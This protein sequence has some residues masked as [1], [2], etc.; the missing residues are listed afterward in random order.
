M[1]RWRATVL[2][3]LLS[4]LAMATLAA[5]ANDADFIFDD[6][7]DG[8]D[9]DLPAV[10]C[11]V[12]E[13]AGVCLIPSVHTRGLVT[14]TPS[15]A[16]ILTHAQA[17]AGDVDTKRFAGE[18]LGYVTPWNNH[19]YDMAKT[20]RRKFTYIA[21]VWYQIRHD[22]ARTPVLTG[23]HDADAN[24]IDAVRGHDGLGP[25]IVPRFMF[26]MPSLSAAEASQVLSLLLREVETH[27]FDGLT[28]EVPIV[29]VTVPFIKA[30]GKAL[31]KA[32]RLLLLVLP[33]S[34]RN[35]Q[36]SVD[37]RH[38]QAVLPYVHRISV[39]AYDYSSMGPNAPLPWL[40]ATLQQLTPPHKLL[41]GLA[42]YGYDTN[43]AVIASTY[44][45]LLQTH[46]PDVQWDAVA[47]EC[48]FI[49]AAGRRHVYYPCLQ[50]IDDRL[51]LY[52]KAHVGAAI[53]EIGQGLD[54]FYDLL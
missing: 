41:M 18:T 48:K 36:L 16:S 52:A 22:A 47:H 45:T 25:Q 44:L 38:L 7:D 13:A 2:A 14:T 10:A 31:A 11:V 53:W 49:Y 54:Y 12:D 17:Y 34:Q 42:F 9:D 30:L 40:Q 20:F 33:T 28:L 43:E 5:A 27:H 4:A 19:G 29:D 39:N 23:G 26:E 46:T 21:P 8:H 24:W 35:G 51:A 15:V 1:R 6:A 32:K 37:A 50:S 3:L